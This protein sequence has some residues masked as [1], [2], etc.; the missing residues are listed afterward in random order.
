MNGSKVIC[1][2]GFNE[3]FLL[4]KE[5]PSS[6][7]SAVNPVTFLSNKWLKYLEVLANSQSFREIS[8]L[9]ALAAKDSAIDLMPGVP[10]Q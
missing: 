2:S 8:L 1:K 3:F 6:V 10:T 9:C 5:R 4:R 7:N